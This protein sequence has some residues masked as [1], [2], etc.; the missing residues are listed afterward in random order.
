MHHKALIP[1]VLGFFLVGIS[2]GRLSIIYKVGFNDY[3]HEKICRPM[4]YEECIFES[5]KKDRGRQWC[6]T[7]DLGRMCQLRVFGELTKPRLIMACVDVDYLKPED[8]Q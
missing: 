4:P 5:D 8:A 3:M 1:F 6:R 7:E 2:I